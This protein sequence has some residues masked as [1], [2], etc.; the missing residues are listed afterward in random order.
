MLE[1]ASPLTKEPSGRL[2]WR[3]EPR[4]PIFEHP[5]RTANVSD[6]LARLGAALADRYRLERE[7]GSGGMAT[8]YLAEDLKHHRKVAVKVL[9]PDLAA[10]LGPDRFVREIT[11]AAGLSHPHILPLHDSGQ[12]DGFLYYVMP[13]VEGQSLRE[14]LVREGELPIAD[15]VRILH[16]VADALAYAHRHGVVHRDIKPENVMLSDR[17]ALV[18]D[19]GVAKAVSEATGRQALTTAGVALG[20]PTYMS[21]EQ[22]AA[23][24]HTDHR[25]DIYAFGVLAYELL[26]GRPPFTGSTPQSVLA[27]HVTMPAE[28]VTRYRTSIPPIL[29][30]LVMKCLEKRPA[31]RWQ[32]VDELIPQLETVLTPSGGITPTATQPVSAARPRGQRAIGFGLVAVVALA[33]LGWLVLRSG[34][35]TEIDADVI[36]V[37]PFDVLDPKLQIWHEGMV[38]ILARALDG[39]G[40]FRTVAPSVV[41]N[42]WAGRADQASAQSLGRRTGAGVVVY[43][44]L[45]ATGRDSVRASAALLDTRT[46][47]SLGEIERRD[48]AAGMDRLVDSVAYALLSELGRT[49]SVAAFKRS[50]LG[51]HSL[52]A[53][54][55]FLQG[56][57][58]MRAANYDS[59]LAAYQQAIAIDSAFPQ[60][61][62]RA[63]LAVGWSKSP[64]DPLAVQYGVRAGAFNH[65]LSP[66]DSLLI[67]LDSLGGVSTRDPTVAWAMRKRGFSTLDELVR[68]YPDDPETWYRLGESRWHD[69]TGPGVNATDRQVLEAFDHAIALDSS[70]A[71]AYEHPIQLA[72]D[73]DG[74][75]R[76]L[77]YLDGMRRAMRQDPPSL[78]I[79]LTEAALRGQ[80]ALFDRL[81]DSATA[82]DLSTV[83]LNLGS[84]ADSGDFDR[85][86]VDAAVA[87]RA[88]QFLYGLDSATTVRIRNG[89]LTSRGHLREGCAGWRNSQLGYEASW[90]ALLGAVSPDSSQAVFQDWWRGAE[91][92]PDS[93][94]AWVRVY[95]VLPWWAGRRDV[96]T[97]TAIEN[98]M[99][100]AQ[101][102]NPPFTRWTIA[103]RYMLASV[104]AYLAL[105][106]ADSARALE[107]FRTLPDSLCPFCS[108]ELLARAQLEFALRDA[109]GA[110]RT[111][112]YRNRYESAQPHL[113]LWELTRARAA[114]E[115][116][117]RELALRSYGYVVHSWEQ[118]DPPVQP[119]V[120]EARAGLQRL[121]GEPKAK[122]SSP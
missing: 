23:D 27:A 69:R 104:R 118:G 108:Q 106:R 121:T 110:L 111:L 55:A 50:G 65:G 109:T 48:L 24:P 81:L 85:K 97:L 116:G 43:G 98:A 51:G 16:D 47:K 79:R 80:Q 17:H 78:A 32:S 71:P 115:V 40:P 68:R 105:A 44:S 96:G 8:V 100:T 99:A 103:S 91:R 9:R 21:P 30:A 89:R 95:N 45:V 64:F 6:L 2:N 120:Q 25:A 15:T 12:A 113:V 66:R 83:D 37:A 114:E 102:R 67:L 29:A 57:Q 38:D 13:F 42:H 14:K 53:L 74:P 94:R 63:S 46:G 1:R 3:I 73:L 10:T 22:A 82:A 56:E 5:P 54:K 76:A 34:G 31:D 19:F 18:T 11:I 61:L 88:G 119:Y 59:A 4:R 36:A 86:V 41:I 7:L 70:F 62:S 20:T 39:A 75:A 112:E 52:P 72:L 49:R 35:K 87:G 33:L 77:G 84:W 90:C 28:P 107:T 26:A 101:N 93:A 58:F 122:A 117:N 92:S 60:A